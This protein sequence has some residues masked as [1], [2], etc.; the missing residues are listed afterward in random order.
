MSRL[1]LSKD[2]ECAK[3]PLELRLLAIRHGTILT[4]THQLLLRLVLIGGQ[5]QNLDRNARD[6]CCDQCIKSVVTTFPN[7]RFNGR[8]SVH[9]IAFYIC[10]RLT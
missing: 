7:G 3:A 10:N 4:Q 6:I 1:G 5:E 8:Q 9:G 2:R